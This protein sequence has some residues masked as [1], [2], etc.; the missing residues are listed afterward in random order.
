MNNSSMSQYNLTINPDLKSLIPPL[1]SDEFSQL[2]ANV[3]ADGIR[4]PIIV[5]NG[6]IVDGHNRYNLA[7]KH[8]LK[9]ETLEMQFAEFCDAVDWM[10]NN[11][12][13]RRNLTESQKDHLIGK[14]YQNEKQRLGGQIKS[15]ATNINSEGVGKNFPPLSTAEKLGQ[16]YGISARQVKF[17]EDFAKGV[18]LIAKVDSSKRDDI[19]LEK[20]NLTKGE[21]QQF[22]KLQKQVEKEVKESSFFVSRE[23]QEVEI[24]KRAIEL[25][26]QKLKILEEEKKNYYLK[27]ANR[28][29][30]SES[31]PQ[32]LENEIVSK[33]YQINH[34]D[35]FLVNGCHKLIVA[36]S[37]VDIDF[38]K[39]HAVNIDCVLTDPPYGV[40]YKSPSG[41][42]LTQRGDY[43]VIEGDGKEFDPSILFKYSQNVITWGANHYANRLENSAGWIVWDKREGSAINL[44]SDCEMAWSNMLNSARLFHHTWN[45][46]IKASEHNTKRIHPTQKPVKLFEFCLEVTKAGRVVIDL[47]AGSGTIIP[48]CD[49]SSRIAIAVEKDYTYVAAI[50]NRMESL[51]FKV[52]RV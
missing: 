41:S 29:K 28:I 37:F 33:T 48:A 39:S 38:I 3:L 42:A 24:E 20:S 47:F 35:V 36:D 52:E 31:L 51:G 15:A 44:N 27:V 8:G 6:T 46:M 30:E 14:R 2:E 1:T 12:L 7:Q 45:G 18:D 34:K 32:S 50:L 21:V 40:S 13:G 11:Q 25:A 16:E 23:E 43:K 10:V 17:N 5:W 49:R 9:F 26:E 22:S 4:D 19:L